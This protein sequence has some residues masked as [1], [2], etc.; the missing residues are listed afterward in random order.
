MT[1]EIVKKKNT[2]INTKINR[3]SDIILIEAIFIELKKSSLA[4]REQFKC[5]NIRREVR[6]E[7]VL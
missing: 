1:Q 4:Y 7:Y 6:Q 2:N 5:I 3:M